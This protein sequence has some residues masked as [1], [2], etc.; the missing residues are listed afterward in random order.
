MNVWRSVFA[1]M[2]ALAVPVVANAQTPSSGAPMQVTE[3]VAQ[4]TTLPTTAV[5]SSAPAPSS[6]SAAS[7]DWAGRYARGSVGLVS[8]T[9]IFALN[10]NGI[11]VGGGGG[12]TAVLGAIGLGAT[13]RIVVSQFVIQPSLGFNGFST[14]GQFFFM[15]TPGVGIGAALPLTHQIALTPMFRSDFYL[16]PG[17]GIGGGVGFG[18]ALVGEL[19]VTIFLGRNG[20]FEPYV[21]LGALIGGLSSAAFLAGVGYRLGVIF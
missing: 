21:D 16:F 14:G 1:G 12:G 10:L 9:A 11:L 2:V 6:S 4:G 13:A 18:V 17:G 5:S 8:Q 20:F 3:P 19:P 7:D 15:F